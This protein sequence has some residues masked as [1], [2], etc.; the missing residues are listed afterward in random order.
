MKNLFSL[1]SL[2]ATTDQKCLF[3][4]VSVLVASAL[5][6]FFE[7]ILIACV[8]LFIQLSFRDAPLSYNGIFSSYVA[9]L[10][11]I[12]IVFLLAIFFA[13]VILVASLRISCLYL[14]EYTSREIGSYLAQNV[15]LRVFSQP[16][17]YYRESNKSNILNSLTIN[18]DLTVFSISNLFTATTAALISLSIGITLIASGTSTIGA[19]LL[20]LGVIYISANK[21]ATSSLNSISSHTALEIDNQTVNLLFTYDNIKQIILNNSLFLW[22]SRFIRI[23]RRIRFLN[24]RA[25][26]LISLP[27]YI[28]ESLTILALLALIYSFSFSS[29]SENVL[30]TLSFIVIGLQRL[31]SNLQIIFRCYGVIKSKS[32]QVNQ[33]IHY[34]SLPF[35]PY[36]TQHKSRKINSITL[37]HISYVHQ[38]SPQ[39]NLLTNISFTLRSGYLNAIVGPSGCGKSTILDILM[40]LLTPTSG[41]VYANFV[42][43]NNREEIKSYQQ[44]ISHVTQRSYF[45]N[46][47]ILDNIIQ[48]LPY[49]RVKL[50][51]VLKVTQLLPVVNSIDNGLDYII[52]DNGSGLSG[53]QL[54]RIALARALYQD[55]SV[56]VLDEST[57]ALDKQTEHELMLQLK[58]YYRDR[59]IIL[60]THNP[61]LFSLCDHV[62]ELG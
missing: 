45:S 15:Y 3:L 5:S 51:N 17:V 53:G 23:D 10:G 22:A 26:V 7:V 55:K 25:G 38:S 48:F 2:L 21:L 11:N 33:V 58:S 4:S 42:C 57:S 46:S 29:N 56:L 44:Q 20:L 40:C 9:I 59:L 62:I 61:T 47:S 54:Q 35:D 39:V 1:I 13:I 34:L 60:V 50:E 16:Y 31:V 41:Y 30:A 14:T 12:P 36:Y 24:Y 6:S 52:G 18:L 28:I 8:P 37:D 49:D 19:L 32:A 43:L 27:R